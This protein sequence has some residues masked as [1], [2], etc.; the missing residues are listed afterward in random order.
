MKHLEEIGK[1][2]GELTIIEI[3]PTKN[4]K[5]RV[6]CK[7]SCGNTKECNLADLKSG[8]T[9]TCGQCSIYSMI[10]Q[11]YEHLTVLEYKGVGNSGHRMFLCQCDCGNQI[12]VSGTRLKNHKLKSCGHCLPYEEVGKRYGKLVVTEYAFSKNQKR[13]W[14]CQCD[15]GNIAYVTTDH[16]H[17][18]HSQSCGCIK[19]QKVEYI[20]RLLTELEVQYK[21]EYS[22]E[23]LL[24]Q[25]ILRFDFAVLEPSLKLIEFDGEQHFNASEG[26]GGQDKLNYIQTHDEMK[27]QYCKENNIPLLRL[28]Y[29]Q[30]E[31]EIKEEIKKF[32]DIK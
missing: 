5:T 28:N 17:S 32:F 30:T 23:D 15:C 6:L 25:K 11:K 31:E 13:Y 19:S 26:W 27:N 10:G 2:Y 1:T 9:R 8:N 22:F 7:C 29:L 18:G 4:N 16:L 21:T 3:L 14:K 12:I 20:T 24:D